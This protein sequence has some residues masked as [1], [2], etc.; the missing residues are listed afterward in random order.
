MVLLESINE[1]HLI[2]TVNRNS[3]KLRRDSYGF[4]GKFLLF[5]LF[6][7]HTFTF[8]QEKNEK[9]TFSSQSPMNLF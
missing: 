9:A 3:R 1:E 8:Y 5:T 4:H 7:G 2:R 6:S